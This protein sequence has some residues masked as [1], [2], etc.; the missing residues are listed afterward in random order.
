MRR[1]HTVP[2][3][4]IDIISLSPVIVD[5][6]WDNA[7]RI[8]KDHSLRTEGALLIPIGRI[9]VQLGGG[10]LFQRTYYDSEKIS[11]HK[12]YFIN[13]TGRMLKF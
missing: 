13:I 11:D 8:Q 4:Q 2:D 1:K 9:Y 5:A 10:I 12:N 3:M 6:Y 7:E